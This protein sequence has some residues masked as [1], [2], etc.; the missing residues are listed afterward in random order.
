MF[1]MAFMKV[2]VALIYLALSL[3][4]SLSQVKPPTLQH[5]SEHDYATNLTGMLHIGVC[6]CNTEIQGVIATIPEPSATV[7]PSYHI[8]NDLLCLS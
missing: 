6:V 7:N 2:I 4:L 3:S 1:A 8:P 5:V